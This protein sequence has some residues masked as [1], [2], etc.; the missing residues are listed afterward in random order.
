[1]A[2]D[3]GPDTGGKPARDLEPVE[4]DLIRLRFRDPEVE[5]RYRREQTE[6]VTPFVRFALAGGCI[7]Y[8]LFGI[9]DAY[10]IDENLEYVLA[11]RFLFGCGTLLAAM[12]LTYTPVFQRHA[13]SIVA[14]AMMNCGLGVIAMTIIAPPPANETYYAGLI[15]VL[16]Y[17]SVLIHCRF[18][19]NLAVTVTLVVVYFASVA[20]VAP[21]PDEIIVNNAYFLLMSLGVGVFA[22]Y[23]LE[24][25]WRQRFSRYLAL[26][27]ASDVAIELKNEAVS[28]NHAKTEFLATM[29]HEL[30]T[31]LNAILG[32]SE[33]M[34]SELYGPLGSAKYGDYAEDIH[35]SARQLLTIISDILDYAKSETGSFELEETELNATELMERA[36]RTCHQLA[37]SKGVRVSVATPEWT[38]QIKGDGR[39]LHQILVNLISNGIK[40]TP[41][42]GEV[43]V[44]VSHAEEGGCRFQV[45]DTGIGISEE[46]QQRVFEPFAQ[47][48]SA[49]ARDQGGAGLG[50]PMVRRLAQMH[51]G[52]VEMTS[53]LG[54]GTTVVVNLPAERMTGFVEFD[55]Q[56]TSPDMR[57]AC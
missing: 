52:Q 5:D 38:P 7:L 11:I 25:G 16:F 47:V 56:Q 21:L 4:I 33:M 13:Q 6:R 32:F 55:E 3:T 15:M 27:H 51:E 37:A 40:F 28:A 53:R 35:Q 30:R 50:L 8:G 49:F 41:S 9:L 45:A 46:D 18:A 19:N 10:L 36:V 17:A 12:L 54:E 2:L 29:S 20:T 1:M 31:P 44:S 48:Q 39:L 42:A 23:T 14:L 24:L 22:C 57:Q 26:E 43:R 34:K